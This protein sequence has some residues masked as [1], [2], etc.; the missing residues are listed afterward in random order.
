M[1]LRLSTTTTT[2]TATTTTVNNT[3]AAVAVEQWHRWFMVCARCIFNQWMNQRMN[4]WIK[5]ATTIAH[6]LTLD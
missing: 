3:A 4:E 5:D 6:S 2:T 1:R